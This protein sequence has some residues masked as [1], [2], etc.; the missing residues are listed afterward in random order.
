MSDQAIDLKPL[1]PLLR[2]LIRSMG[3]PATMILLQARGG[4]RFYLGGV[5]AR[6]DRQLLRDLVGVDASQAFYMEFGGGKGSE[7]TLPKV[8]KIAMQIRDRAIR[9]DQ[10]HSLME[11]ALIHRLT[12]RQIQNIRRGDEKPEWA[13]RQADLFGETGTAGREGV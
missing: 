9:A 5:H 4:T 8:D 7:V 6:R 3:L 1:P 2:R 11:L 13:S 10:A 12:T